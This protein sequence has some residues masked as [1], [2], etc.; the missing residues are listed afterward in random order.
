MENNNI[1]GRSNESEQI[2]FVEFIMQL[3]RGKIMIIAFVIG[4]IIL[5]GVY[6]AFA[7][8][9]WTSTA[10]I[11]QP[12]VGQIASYNNVMNVLY[13]INAPKLPDEQYGLIVRF[14][15]AFAALSEALDNQKIPEKLSLEPSVK[16]QPLPLAVSYTG[17]TAE[18]AQRQLAKYIQQVDEQIAKELI[19]DVSDNIK[20]QTKILQDSLKTQEVVAQE[21]KSLRITQIQEALKYANEARIAKPQ[22][23]Q[24]QDITQDSMFLLGSEALTSM[25]QNEATRPLVFSDNYYQTK[26]NLLDIQNVKLDPTSIHVYRYVMKPTLP[27]RRDSPKRT[28]ILILAALVGVMIGSVYVLGRNALHNYSP[29]TK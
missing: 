12:D 25:I 19:V 28:I 10:I 2:D 20:L 5:A 14:S 21:Q 18:G 3:W 13:G 6:L 22:P 9:K 24:A 27:I 17:S 26:Q 16:G 11:T 7:K 8:E 29:R 23:L 1:Y 15:S 4:A